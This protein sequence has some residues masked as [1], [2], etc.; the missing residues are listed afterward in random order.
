MSEPIVTAT[1]SP[2]VDQ[3]RAERVAE[4]GRYTAAQPIYIGGALAF[5]AD[6]PVPVS[7]VERG[8]VPLELVHE[9]AVEL[10]PDT[11]TAVEP[12]A[13]ASLATWQEYARSR[14]ATD[15]DLEGATRDSLRDTYSTKG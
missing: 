4:Y 3:R 1:T 2:V 13:N 10:A 15:G 6:D 12:A 14:G 7:H 8:V 9:R 5:N 11:G